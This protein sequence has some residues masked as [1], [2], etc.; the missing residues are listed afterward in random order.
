M[1]RRPSL[2]LLTA[3]SAAVATVGNTV[4]LAATAPG[5]GDAPTSRL[6]V[7]IGDDMKAR[8]QAAARRGRALDLRE[9]AA[10]AAEARL[11][12]AD[13][14]T[15][16]AA[17]GTAPPPTG[18]AASAGPDQYDD[19]AR[20]YQVMKPTAAAVVLEQLDLD[21]QMRVAQ[22]M[23]ERSTAMILA[24]MTP[25]GAAALTMAMARRR[26]APTVAAVPARR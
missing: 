21:V 24:A 5:I 7:A 15:P 9:Q 20:I 17:P 19:L 3:F 14:T 10:R 22:K 26:A 18:E 8:D 1:S 11:K 23:R 25:K 2:L 16:A 13:G 6:G 12:P 4:G